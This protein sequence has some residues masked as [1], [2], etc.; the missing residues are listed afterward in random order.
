MTE[1]L[2]NK[3]HAYKI[4]VGQVL[5][6][7]GYESRGRK[8]IYQIQ[9]GKYFWVEEESL[10]TGFDSLNFLKSI[11]DKFGI[12]IYYLP[13]QKVSEQEVTNLISEAKEKQRKD[14]EE[15][16]AREEEAKRKLEAE[17]KALK[18][19]YP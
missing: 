8:I 2:P 1:D 6:M 7:E 3:E 15:R 14:E 13:G 10:K 11:E 18:E 19:L 5:T 16:P 4:E 12:S 17:T 9:D